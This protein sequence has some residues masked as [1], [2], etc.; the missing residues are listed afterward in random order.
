[1]NTTPTTAQGKVAPQK[2]SDTP[3]PAGARA[4]GQDSTSLGLATAATAKLQGN[5]PDAPLNERTAR[6]IL[7]EIQACS[8]SVGIGGFF[9]ALWDL[10]S[11]PST[12]SMD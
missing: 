4:V 7:S 1:M 9:R 12:K 5:R 11:N 6:T 10:I 8:K 2:T 3:S